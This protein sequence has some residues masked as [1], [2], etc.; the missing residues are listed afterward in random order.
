MSL[1]N[2]RYRKAYE[3]PYIFSYTYYKYTHMYAAVFYERKE[4]IR[5]VHSVFLVSKTV[6][7][8]SLALNKYLLGW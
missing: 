5:L 3:K 1:I 8:T 6:S 4:L 7:D 2:W